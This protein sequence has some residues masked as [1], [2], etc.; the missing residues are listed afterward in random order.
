M[1]AK[2]VDKDR[3]DVHLLKLKYEVICNIVYCQI[4]K[5]SKKECT[6]IDFHFSL[7]SPQNDLR[8]IMQLVIWKAFNST[9]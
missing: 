5:L 4:T 9:K 7:I 2:I 8:F 3:F 6:L 1:K